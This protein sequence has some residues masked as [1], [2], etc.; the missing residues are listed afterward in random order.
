MNSDIYGID[1]LRKIATDAYVQSVKS[2]AQMLAKAHVI[3]DPTKLLHPS[4]V[5]QHKEKLNGGIDGALSLY[6]HMLKTAA[7]VFKQSGVYMN[8]PYE[9]VELISEMARQMLIDYMKRRKDERGNG[10]N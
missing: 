10:Q 9:H 1:K 4:F 8:D 7:D 2:E 6:Y 5:A 3:V